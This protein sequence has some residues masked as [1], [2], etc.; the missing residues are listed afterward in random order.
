MRPVLIRRHTHTRVSRAAAR[1]VGRGHPRGRVRS[2]DYE[3][4]SVAPRPRRARSE[5]RRDPTVAGRS[6]TLTLS[7]CRGPRRL[8]AVRVYVCKQRA[9]AN[10]CDAHAT[11]E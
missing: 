10:V 1:R 3:R 9:L 8:R 5:E 11:R 7:R 6:L 2:Y 4:V